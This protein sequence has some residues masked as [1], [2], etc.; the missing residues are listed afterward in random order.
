MAKLVTYIHEDLK[1]KAKAKAALKG[2]S[3]SSIINALLA[4]W[5]TETPERQEKENGNQ[6]PQVVSWM[7]KDY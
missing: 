7:P 1:R 4:E 5:L 6:E 2:K 3:L